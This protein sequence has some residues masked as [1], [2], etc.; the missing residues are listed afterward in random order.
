MRFK[1]MRPRLLDAWITNGL[2]AQFYFTVKYKNKS[3][4]NDNNDDEDNDND[5]Q[6]KIFN[7]IQLNE[8]KQLIVSLPTSG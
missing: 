3:K 2:Q 8:K 4:N 5:S 1:L 6:R 7:N